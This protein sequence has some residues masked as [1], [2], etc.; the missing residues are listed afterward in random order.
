MPT[1]E[2]DGR[3]KP[4]GPQVAPEAAD[5]FARRTSGWRDWPEEEVLAPAGAPGH[6]PGTARRIGPG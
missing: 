3:S 4:V 6:R 2:P 5:W 1:D